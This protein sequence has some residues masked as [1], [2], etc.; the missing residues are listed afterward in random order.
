MSARL[1]MAIGTLPTP[2]KRTPGKK[3]PDDSLRRFGFVTDKTFSVARER[4]R[5]TARGDFGTTAFFF[6]RSETVHH[7]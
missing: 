1:T 7:L 5:G 6:T 2:D 3:S 4:E